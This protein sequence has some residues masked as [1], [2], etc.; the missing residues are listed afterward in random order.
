[1][2]QI[3]FFSF[4]III[5]TLAFVV[6]SLVVAEKDKDLD[7]SKSL[8]IWIIIC[9]VVFCCLNLLNFFVLLLHFYGIFFSF[10]IVIGPLLGL[11]ELIWCII[12]LVW[13]TRD[14]VKD[15]CGK[16]YN[17]TLG[18]SIAILVYSFVLC[19]FLIWDIIHLPFNV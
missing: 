18:D 9:N 3:Y 13:A 4:L 8:W 10:S 6:P 17:V 7:C 1:M 15:Q 19:I 2:V 14:G 11:F 12:G 5:S 16:L